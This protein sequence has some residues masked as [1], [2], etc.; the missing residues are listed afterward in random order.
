[1]VKSTGIPY[2]R[3]YDIKKDINNYNEGF[4]TQT[5]C[6]LIPHGFKINYYL[7]KSQVIYTC[8]FESNT[9]TVSDANILVESLNEN[10]V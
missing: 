10:F 1:M 9:W 5:Y 2:H 8:I 7:E 3:S 6:K 4:F